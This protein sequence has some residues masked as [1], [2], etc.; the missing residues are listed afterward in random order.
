MRG[1]NFQSNGQT[2]K[3]T[4]RAVLTTDS[5]SEQRMDAILLQ[6]HRFGDSSP[7]ISLLMALIAEGEYEPG[8]Q[9]W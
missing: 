3:K 2:P 6:K 8:F 5:N 9:S 4:V 1:L 7:I